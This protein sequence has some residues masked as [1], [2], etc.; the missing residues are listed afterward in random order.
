MNEQRIALVAGGSRGIGA[1]VVRRLAKDGYAVAVGYR[2]ARAEAD[3]IVSAVEAGGGQALA[4][5]GDIGRDG[6]PARMV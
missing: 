5:Q 4:V 3:A 1:A 6:N 2:S